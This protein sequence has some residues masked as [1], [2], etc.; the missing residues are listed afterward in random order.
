MDLELR[1]NYGCV[2]VCVSHPLRISQGKTHISDRERACSKASLMTRY[3]KPMMRNKLI[4][5]H[6]I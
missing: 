6:L 2:C 3:E 4:S 5:H 1:R